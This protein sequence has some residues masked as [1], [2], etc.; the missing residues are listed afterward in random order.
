MARAAAAWLER[1]GL[2]ART[3]TVKVRYADFTTATR[4]G[5]RRPP[6]R[7]ADDVVRRALVLLERTDA[8]VRPVRLLGVA[9]TTSPSRIAGMAGCSRVRP[10]A[11]RRQ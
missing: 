2:F 4:N 10:A 7:D 9:S 5:S 11:V 3:V 8:G 6:T 1:H